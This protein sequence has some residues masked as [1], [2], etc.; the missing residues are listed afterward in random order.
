M[1][2]RAMPRPALSPASVAPLVEAR[3]AYRVAA[4]LTEGQAELPHDITERLKVSRERALERAAQRAR[5]A[6][7]RHAGA[8]QVQGGG[9][10]GATLGLLGG[11]F[12]VGASRWW[13][14]ASVLPLVALVI[15]LVAIQQRHADVQITE[16]AQ[17]DADL[18]GDAL[19]P[20][21]YRDAGFVEFL[22][23][24]RT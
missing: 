10:G 4:A 20:D 18:L 17:I 22:K 14:F 7:P 1:T 24:P 23:A 19:P 3:F 8:T 16:A 6:A 11:G 12:D 2:L 13:R 5:A 21:A 9:R 15:G